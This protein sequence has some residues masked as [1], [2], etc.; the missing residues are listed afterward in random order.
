M[1]VSKT[2]LRPNRSEIVPGISEKKPELIR[3]T[4]ISHCRWFEPLA[5][6]S[7]A[8][9][10]IAGSNVAKPSDCNAWIMA[11]KTINSRLP[12]DCAIT[13]NGFVPLLTG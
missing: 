8:I 12:M 4:L 7:D 10:P 13:D 11:I 2:G 9:S 6:R 5:P 1:Q 3:K